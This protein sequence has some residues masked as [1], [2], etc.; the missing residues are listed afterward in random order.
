MPNNST[1][2]GP[3]T[4]Q[5]LSQQG[6]LE[7]QALYDFFQGWLVGITGMPGNLFRPRW[8]PEPPNIPADGVTWAAFGITSRKSDVFAAE[9][10]DP[11]NPGYNVMRRHQILSIFVSFYGP[12]A[13]MYSDI[14]NDGLQI[15]QNLELLSLNSMGLIETGECTTVPELVKLKWLQRVDIPIRIRRQI[16]RNFGV[17]TILSA[18]GTLDNEVYTTPFTAQ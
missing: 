14:L 4:P 11:S 15:A 8:Q 3:L 10:P 17:E 12:D 18:S 2:G 9:F 5:T 7:G 6:V 1:T 13:G 16:V